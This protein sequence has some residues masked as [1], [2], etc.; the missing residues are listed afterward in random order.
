M[1]EQDPEHIES[2]LSE[3]SVVAYAYK[4]KKE[5]EAVRSRAASR[6]WRF[7][8][9]GCSTGCVLPVGVLMLVVGVGMA[10]AEGS[11][12][13]DEVTGFA[14]FAGTFA[15]F[16]TA[17]LFLFAVLTGWNSKELDRAEEDMKF[18]DDTIRDG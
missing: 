8:C 11:L 18:V 6:K 17:L 7:G 3:R 5:L 2:E 14:M 13:S 16:L 12:N 10:A 9:L 15:L 1:A 4:T